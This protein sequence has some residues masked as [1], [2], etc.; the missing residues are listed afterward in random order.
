MK[1]N[2]TKTT[3]T[4]FSLSTKEQKVKLCINGQTLLAENNPTYLGVT[5]DRRLTWKKQAEKAETRG[6]VRLALMK[7]LAG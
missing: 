3:Y 2:A 4:V 1:I 7:K 6:K 5:F